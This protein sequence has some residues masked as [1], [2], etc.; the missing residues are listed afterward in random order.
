MFIPDASNNHISFSH[1][2][3]YGTDYGSTYAVKVSTASQTSHGDFTDI[4]TWTEADFEPSEFTS[5]EF[6]LAAY[7]GVPIHVAFVMTND[8]GDDWYI[9]DVCVQAGL[10][11]TD[12]EILD[13]RIYPNPTSSMINVQFD[14]D[15]ELTLYNMLGQEII[16]TN[17]KQVDISALQQGNY[18]VIVR[19]LESNNIK[20][21]NIIKK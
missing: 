17:N 3:A 2:Q 6:S 18:I 20:N 14:R 10:S 8:D 15:I 21:F 4:A 13:M 19:D 12:N 11:T 5:I 9:D 7:I 1:R 16:K